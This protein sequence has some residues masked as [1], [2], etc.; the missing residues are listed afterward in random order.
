MMGVMLSVYRRQITDSSVLKFASWTNL[1]HIHPAHDHDLQLPGL[2]YWLLSADQAS[3]WLLSTDQ[4]SLI[5]CCLLIR[6]LIGG[7]CAI[8]H[9]AR[10][11]DVHIIRVSS[12]HFSSVLL[13]YCFL[14][15]AVLA[16]AFLQ[17]E[18]CNHALRK[19]RL[20]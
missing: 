1:K 15:P 10:I 20:N 3:H 18:V 8:C 17:Q 19:H 13:F 6:P 14:P 9:R 2:S 12:R 11:L 16:K 5:G 4:A 7:K